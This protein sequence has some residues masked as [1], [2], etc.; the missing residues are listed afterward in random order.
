[1]PEP[2]PKIDS[3]TAA[4]VVRDIERLMERPDCAPDL[5]D[6]ATHHARGIA[7]ALIG[8]FGRFAELI[9]ERLNR[10]PEKNFLAYLDLLGNSLLPPQ[11]ARVPLT[12]SLAAGSVADGVVL[13]GTQVAAVQMEGEKEAAVFETERELVVTAARL[14]RVFTR[15]PDEDQYADLSRLIDPESPVGAAVFH[16]DRPIDH[17]FYI[18]HDSLFGLP[19]LAQLKVVFEISGEQ[20]TPLEVRWETWDGS[21]WNAQTPAS[22]TTRAAP[23]SELPAGERPAIDEVRVK[24]PGSFAV[25]GEVVFGPLLPLIRNTVG[26]TE[27]R[28][29]RCRSRSPITRA[30]KKPFFKS[31]KL[32]AKA[33]RNAMPIVS[34]FANSA[35]ADVT[36][37]FFPFGERPIPGDTFYIAAG[38]AFS[39]ADTVVTLHVTVANSPLTDGSPKLR[40][41]YWDGRRWFQLN[42]EPPTP[43][44][45]FKDS[46]AAFTTKGDNAVT[47]KLPAPARTASVNGVEG[48]WIRVRLVSGNYGKPARYEPLTDAAG[49]EIVVNGNVQYKLTPETY[50][51]P[52][53]SSITVDYTLIKEKVGPETVLA[54]NDFAYKNLNDFAEGTFA[55]FLPTSD[56]KPALYLGFTLP[57]EVKA[58]PNKKLS[59]FCGVDAIRF[60]E[61]PAATAAGADEKPRVS[62]DYS[63]PSKP[64]GWSVLRVRDESEAITRQGLVEFLAPSDFALR[65]EFG[66]E[67]YW[68]RAVWDTGQYSF[69]PRLHSLLPNTAMAAHAVTVLDEIIGSS[70]QSGGQSFRTTRSPILEGQEIEVREREMPPASEQE[71]IKT[72]EGEDAISIKS[73]E[74][75]RPQEIWV[76]WSQVADFYGSDARNRHYVIDHLTGEIRFGDGLSGMIP[77]VG[78]G[79][80]RLASYR[81]GGGAAG[82][83]PAGAIT[84][85]KTTVPY[86]E[87]VNNYVAAMGGADAEALESL[88]ERAPR[89]I[90]H[91]DRAVTV[92]DFEDLAMLASPEVA[93]ARAVPLYNLA[94]DPP[95]TRIIP[96]TVS[97]IIVPRLTDARPTPGLELI[98]RVREFIEARQT[99]VADLIVVG[100]Q[101]M[102][103]QVEVEIGLAS[104]EGASSVELAV[105][106]ALARFLH[107]LTGGLDGKG[108]DFGR[109]PHKSDVY[110]LIEGIPGVDHVRALNVIETRESKGAESEGAVD[111]FLVYS[112][113]HKIELK[114]TEA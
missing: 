18:G 104:L 30:T 92:E 47:F 42:P 105:A 58:F 23:P 80:I 66:I 99:P 76:R 24:A 46:T 93:R 90:R 69:D 109:K 3:R 85:L 48:F 56:L 101:Y 94:I 82:N 70:N 73:D 44:T 68:V 102:R 79:N 75:G 113:A 100:P 36:K 19:G 11:P 55:P 67:G 87:K 32:T 43:E 60:G 74:S 40:W 31:I 45:A 88:I 33:V 6:P 16:G 110:A 9:I 81:T 61:K 4:D 57:R 89:T 78:S 98:K 5:I 8:I 22:D 86:V 29:L 106:Q 39:E 17:I 7:A 15:V 20:P 95:G 107:P 112:G 64:S 72:Q 49:K 71:K 103:V 62:W 35:P 51:P 65:A 41:E 108:W 27:S 37:D 84:Q 1:M 97:L 59:I 96:G 91:R 14:A 10:V 53:I 38:E 34:A 111:R 2:A 26:E 13:A 114:F 28:W 77:P 63:S 54:Y 83:K 25:S 52:S 21:A 12:F 50:A